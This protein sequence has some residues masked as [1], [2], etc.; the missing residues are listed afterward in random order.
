M[1]IVR[2][3]I[4]GELYQKEITFYFNDKAFTAR[5]GQT[6][7]AALMRNGI[8]KFGVSRKMNQARGLFCANGRCCSCFMT[9]NGQEHVRTCITQIENGMHVKQN[10]GDPDVRRVIDAE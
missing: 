3:P 6:V 7:A 1:E 10:L 8:R 5:C 2:H 9:V 4:M